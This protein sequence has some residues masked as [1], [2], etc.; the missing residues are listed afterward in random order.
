MKKLGLE[1]ISDRDEAIEELSQNR[2]AVLA[3]VDRYNAFVAKHGE[4][5]A[6]LLEQLRSSIEQYNAALDTANGLYEEAAAEASEYM[7]SRSERWLS[8]DA[9]MAYTEWVRELES[10]SF[11]DGINDVD[12]PED[13]PGDPE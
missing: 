10:V 11:G 7:E 5:Y 2:N 12:L 6:D 9:G 8:S 13:K 3:A 4:E 1:F